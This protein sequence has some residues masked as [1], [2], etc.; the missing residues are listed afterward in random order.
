MS[1]ASPVIV[2]FREDL[3]ISDNPALAQAAESGAPV[4]CIYVHDEASPGIRPLGAAS[5]W[6]LAGS[7]RAL[8]ASL[9]ERGA[10][11]HVLHGSARDIVPALAR[12]AGA[13]AVVWNRRYGAAEIAVDTGIK[14]ALREAGIAASS[15]NGRLIHEPWTLTTKAGGP[16]RVYTPYWRAMRAK[17]APDMPLAAPA[18]LVGAPFPAAGGLRAV[19]VDAL[20]LEP[21]SPDWA[22]GMREAWT[23]GEE[24][25]QAR[26]EAFVTGGMAGYGEARNRPDMPAT[27]QLSPHL[28]FGE[29]SVR[30][31]WHAAEHAEASGSV[32][33]SPG[34]LETFLKELGWREFS[35]YLLHH[36]PELARRDYAPRFEAFPWRSDAGQLD[37]WQR[38]RTGY[39]I[40]D[41]GMRQLWTTGWMHNRVR[42][43]VASFLVKHLLIDWRRGEEWFWDTLVDADPASNSASWQWVAGTGA[44]ASP[45]FRIFNPVLQGAK[46]DP[47]GI[48]VRRWVPELAKLPSSVIHAPWTAPRPILD[49]AGVRLGSSY[50]SPMVPHDEAR[51]RALA[52]LRSLSAKA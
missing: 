20:G 47:D 45:F 15:F 32:R 46:F 2:W 30:Q 19:P 21:T 22:G 17:G 34:D 7:L 26:L 1:A 10:A 25:A 29:I 6:W 5:R 13:G 41:A 18:A 48:Y 23:R 14:T 11:L 51:A 33:A 12:A 50:P 39:P 3:R 36:N 8:D 37:Q 43:I 9:R 44:D 40:V 24:G 4:L 52:A 42:M 27:S 49:A 38:G 16:I 28:R 35:Y 31:C